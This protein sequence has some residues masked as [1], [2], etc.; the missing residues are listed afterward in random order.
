MIRLR[1]LRPED[2]LAQV[3]ARYEQRIERLEKRLRAADRHVSALIAQVRCLGGRVDRWKSLYRDL[4]ADR[5][6]TCVLCADRARAAGPASSPPAVGC[7]AGPTGGAQGRGRGEATDR[8]RPSVAIG[9]VLGGIRER[10]RAESRRP[11]APHEVLAQLRG[12]IT[13]RPLSDD[14]RRSF[15]VD[16]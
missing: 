11:L 1:R 9:I 13:G 6:N 4:A 3:E 16:L 2:R 14:D 8:Y 12:P 15:R 7:E 5:A 10:A